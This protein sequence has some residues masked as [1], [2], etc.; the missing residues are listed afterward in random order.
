MVQL[1]LIGILG[2]AGLVML[3]LGL[4]QWNRGRQMAR[5]ANELALN[6][7]TE[8]PFD[9]PRR[10]AAFSLMQAGHSTQANH[11]LFGRLKGM[12]VRA[13]DL[14]YE[15]GHGTQ[16]Q[17]CRQTVITV[18]DDWNHPT[19]VIWSPAFDCP[20]LLMSD[21][22]KLPSGW[23]V[24]GDASLA[25]RMAGFWTDGR[26]EVLV[27]T[28][29]DVVMLAFEPLGRQELVAQLQNL[30]QLLESLWP[31]TKAARQNP[32]LPG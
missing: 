19:S 27:E 12:L 18:E 17:M 29:R 13:F 28:R 6:F 3:A 15:A 31:E 7:S 4:V 1:L 25:D 22:V 10:Y 14:R 30:L 26:P 21:Y 9:L 8:D 20:V 24:M 5:A 2:V 11:V 23:Q 32:S 16:R